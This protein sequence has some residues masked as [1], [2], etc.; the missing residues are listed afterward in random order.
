MPISSP[1]PR[2]AKVEVNWKLSR[3]AR[4]LFT[5]VTTSGVKIEAH[6]ERPKELQCITDAMNFV[7]AGIENIAPEDEA[8]ELWVELLN[9]LERAQRDHR[10]G[11]TA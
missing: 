8:K 7:K 4:C 10:T 11:A 9:A 2:K 3:E 5:I 6:V 1:P